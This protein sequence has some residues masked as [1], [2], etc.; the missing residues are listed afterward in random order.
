VLSGLWSVES[1][2]EVPVEEVQNDEVVS[3]RLAVTNLDWDAISSIDL[4]VLFRSFC[5]AIG[6]SAMI[7]K[8]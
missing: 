4:L 5:H 8:V 6:G 2:P 3:K 1:L 7:D